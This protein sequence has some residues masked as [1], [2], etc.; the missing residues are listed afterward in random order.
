MFFEWD[1]Y[2]KACFINEI[3]EESDEDKSKPQA[4]IIIPLC[5]FWL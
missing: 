1:A 2:E 3:E 4:K 5:V